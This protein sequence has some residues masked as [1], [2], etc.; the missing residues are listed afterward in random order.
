MSS[1]KPAIVIVPGAFHHPWHYLPLHDALIKSGYEVT[2]CDLPS[3]GPK[4]P[5]RSITPD[6]EV[7][8]KAIQAYIEQGLNVVIVMHSYGG[9]VGTC[10]SEGFRPEDQASGK[11][12]VSLVYLCAFAL[13]KGVPLL[14]PNGGKHASWI[15]PLGAELNT[16]IFLSWD[17][18]PYTPEEVFYNDVEPAMAEEAVKRLRLF[19]ED[20][21]HCPVTYAAWKE[22][23][24]NYLVCELDKAVPP[25]AEEAMANLSGGKWK[26]VEKI[27]AG[28]SPFLSR[29]NETAEFVRRCA[30]EDL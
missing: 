26:R 13:D 19:S 8:R 12:I 14:A 7:V 29:P 20:T 5:V 23:E 17:N 25:E 28:H 1:T 4:E 10:A 2:T 18:P 16:G 15:R 6:V 27:K 3:T 21:C 22:I 30:G 9:I 11:G 24:S